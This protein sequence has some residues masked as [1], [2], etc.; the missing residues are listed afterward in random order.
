MENIN[1]NDLKS[2]VTILKTLDFCDLNITSFEDLMSFESR[3]AE[4][5]DGVTNGD[6][7]FSTVVNM[8]FKNQINKHEKHCEIKLSCDRIVITFTEYLTQEKSIT[9]VITI[10]SLNSKFSEDKNI[11]IIISDNIPVK[12][13]TYKGY[14]IT[15]MNEICRH[16]F[17]DLLEIE[18]FNREDTEAQTR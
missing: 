9:K 10:S 11:G 4:L 8:K 5:S 6:K 3:K 17:K 1:F 14:G 16:D 2:V 18:G 12:F 13:I 7:A 15:D